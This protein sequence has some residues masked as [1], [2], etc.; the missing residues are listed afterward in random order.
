MMDIYCA[1]GSAI[2][3]ASRSLSACEKQQHFS[4]KK[5]TFSTLLAAEAESTGAD[6]GK[7]C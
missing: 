4:S 2:K 3:A 1:F 6:V 7:T 5:K